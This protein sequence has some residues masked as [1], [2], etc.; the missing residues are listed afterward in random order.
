MTP[1][2]IPSLGALTFAVIVSSRGGVFRSAG[3]NAVEGPA[4]SSRRPGKESTSSVDTTIISAEQALQRIEDSLAVAMQSQ[5]SEALE[6]LIERNVATLG[7]GTRDEVSALTT[8]LAAG[9]SRDLSPALARAI[10]D[11][12]REFVAQLSDGVRSHA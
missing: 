12:T 7:E 9:L 1:A 6:V 2:R 10:R 11:G 8:E 3:Q 4:P 5:I